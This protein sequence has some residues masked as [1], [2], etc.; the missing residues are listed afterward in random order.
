MAT[1][2]SSTDVS[3]DKSRAEVERTLTR[4]GATHFGYM[5]EPG[6]VLIAFQKEGRQVRFAIP[7]PDRN[8]RRFTHHSRGVRTPSAA[9]TEYEQAVK[10]KWR[11]LALVVKAKLE[12]VESGIAEFDQEFYGYMV[13]PSGR[14]VYDDT[15]EQVA[16]MIASRAPGRLMLES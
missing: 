13:L 7:M 16:Q 15:Q 2:A 3:S 9:L 11:A 5:S 1:Y 8:E 4:Y 6:R 14:T 12:A 10:Q